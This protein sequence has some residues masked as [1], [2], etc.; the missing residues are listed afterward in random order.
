MERAR[1]LIDLHML[2][3]VAKLSQE[4]IRHNVLTLSNKAAAAGMAIIIIIVIM[5]II[6]ID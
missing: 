2:R 1:S 4:S 6:I 3:T 5:I